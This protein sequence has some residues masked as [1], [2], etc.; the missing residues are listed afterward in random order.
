MHKNVGSDCHLQQQ[1]VEIY[2]GIVVN[3]KLTKHIS[4]Y[5]D[6]LGTPIEFIVEVFA[7]LSQPFLHFPSS[8]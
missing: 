3:I 8:R 4:R 7:S 6:T 2:A 1:E 5:Y